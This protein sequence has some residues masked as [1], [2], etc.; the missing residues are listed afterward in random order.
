M[1]AFLKIPS[2]YNLMFTPASSGPL[3]CVRK[4]VTLSCVV[5]FIGNCCACCRVTAEG[6][7][8]AHAG[9][10]HYQWESFSPELDEN[11]VNKLQSRDR[12][13]NRAVAARPSMCFVPVLV[14]PPSSPNFCVV[15]R[16]RSTSCVVS[17]RISSSLFIDTMSHCGSSWPL[18]DLNMSPTH[19][20]ARCVYFQ[21]SISRLYTYD[22]NSLC[23]TNPSI[24]H[25]YDL[26]PSGP[27]GSI[28]ADPCCHEAKSGIQSGWVAC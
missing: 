5:N 1:S 9:S 24:F 7:S 21:K 27:R 13:F 19:P 11:T 8:S 10:C 4:M 17:G 22:C 28:G 16:R 6:F 20:T 26:R 15:G 12:D 14:S 25:I 2:A 18:V 3:L 23:L